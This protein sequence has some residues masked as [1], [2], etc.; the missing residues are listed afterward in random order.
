LTKN[1]KR[2]SKNFTKSQRH[3][4]FSSY[5]KIQ[6]KIYTKIFKNYEKVSHPQQ[7]NSLIKFFYILSSR[8]LMIF[9]QL[10]IFFSLNIKQTST[11]WFQD[12]LRI[13]WQS[14]CSLC[15]V[16]GRDYSDDLKFARKSTD[17]LVGQIS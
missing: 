6:K 14:L 11:S 10:I 15:K 17:W 3:E 4:T 5:E 16:V 13:K 9:Q 12:Y 2:C 8:R 1:P 7:K